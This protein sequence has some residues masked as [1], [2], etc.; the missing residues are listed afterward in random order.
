MTGNELNMNP[1]FS[2]LLEENMKKSK[3]IITIITKVLFVFIATIV[4]AMVAALSNM[5]P[6]YAITGQFEDTNI[7][8]MLGFTRDQDPIYEDDDLNPFGK[9]VKAQAIMSELVLSDTT[10]F[11]LF[12]HDDIY[13]QRK[14]AN[15]IPENNS[16]TVDLTY[17]YDNSLAIAGEFTGDGYDDGM[18]LVGLDITNVYDSETDDEDKPSSYG[19]QPA[20]N[21]SILFMDPT[22]SVDT[23]SPYIER[24]K[25]YYANFASSIDKY[26]EEGD[27]DGEKFEYSPENFSRFPYQAQNYLEAVTGDFTGDGIDELAVYFANTGNAKVVVYQLQGQSTSTGTTKSW[28]IASNWVAV[29]TFNLNCYGGKT[30]NMVDLL[31]E[32]L[33]QDGVDDLLISSGHYYGGGY[34]ETH[35]VTRSVK[36]EDDVTYADEKVKEDYK[37]TESYIPTS[38]NVMLGSRDGEYL[39]DSA[40]IPVGQTVRNAFDV[41]DVDGDGKKELIMGAQHLDQIRDSYFNNRMLVAYEFDHYLNN[42]RSVGG[43]NINITETD[44]IYATDGSDN[45]Y[46]SVPGMKANLACVQQEDK[47]NPELIYLDSVMYEYKSGNFVIENRM[48]EDGM[49]PNFDDGKGAEEEGCSGDEYFQYVE[50]GAQSAAYDDSFHEQVTTFQYFPREHDKE[51]SDD[52]S[53]GDNKW[54]EEKWNY[55]SAFWWWHDESMYDSDD[56]KRD[57]GIGDYYTK[58]IYMND[59]RRARLFFL[60]FQKP[61]FVDEDETDEG[62]PMTVIGERVEYSVGIRIS[63]KESTTCIP[64]YK[65]NVNSDNDTCIFEYTGDHFMM[66]SEPEVLAVV[67]SP[68]YFSDLE[69]LEGGD[70][71]IGDS[72]SLYYTIEGT[73]YSESESETFRVGA[74]VGVAYSWEFKLFGIGVENTLSLE[75]ETEFEFTNETEEVI[76][77]EIEL[78]FG[79]MGGQD[80]VAL[81]MVPV[82]VFSYNLKIPDGNGGYN[83]EETQLL[84]KHSPKIRTYSVG[85]YDQIAQYYEELPTVAGK[86][87]THTVGSPESYFSNYSVTE[88][89]PNIDEVII[90]DGPWIEVGYDANSFIEYN[91]EF[92]E[93]TTDTYTNNSTVNFTIDNEIGG[94]FKVNFGI[95][96]G[97]S[98]EVAR[99]TTNISGRGFGC[100]LVNMPDEAEDYGYKYSIKM[101]KYTYFMD[102]GAASEDAEDERTTIPVFTYLVDDVESPPTLPVDLDIMNVTKNSATLTWTLPRW[103]ATKV[104]Y[105]NIYRPITFAS[106]NMDFLIGTVSAN[107][108]QFYNPTTD[109]Y[110]YYMTDSSLASDTTYP[111]YIEAIQDRIEGGRS[112]QSPIVQAHTLPDVPLPTITLSKNYVLAYA[113]EK[114]TITSQISNIDEAL[115]TFYQWEK[116]EADKFESVLGEEAS[117]L[118]LNY[119]AYTDEGEYRL[120]VNQELEGNILISSYSNILTVDHSKRLPI[121]TYD[122]IRTDAG[123][124]SA[125]VKIINSNPNSTSYP[126]GQVVF[127]VKDSSGESATIVKDVIPS[128]VN[129]YSYVELTDYESGDGVFYITATYNGS[130]VFYPTDVSERQVIVGQN[131][132]YTLDMNPAVYYGDY[133]FPTVTK[134]TYD[135]NLQQ[136]SIAEDAQ[137]STY[138]VD[139]HKGDGLAAVNDTL[140]DG[141]FAITGAYAGE[142]LALLKDSNGV[143]LVE[144]TFEVLKRPITITIPHEQYVVGNAQEQQISLSNIACLT[145]TNEAYPLGESHFEI[146]TDDKVLPFLEGDLVYKNALGVNVEIDSS[147]SIGDYTSTLQPLSDKACMVKRYDISFENGG[148]SVTSQPYDV[149]VITHN[150]QGEPAGSVSVLSPYLVTDFP[151]QF[152]RDTQVLFEANPN[153][154]YAVDYWTINA[155]I[156]QPNDK[157]NE[158]VWHLMDQDIQVDVYF[159]VDDKTLTYGA[160]NCILECTNSNVLS[161][162]DVVIEGAQYTFKATPDAG[163]T[164][165]KWVLYED[166]RL[167][168]EVLGTIDENGISTYDIK[169]KNVSTVFYAVAKRSEYT[170][171]LGENLVGSYLWDNDNNTQ[172][173]DV[174]EKFEGTKKL[175]GD[176]ALTVEPLAGYAISQDQETGEYQW[177]TDPENVGAVAANGQS[178]A[179]S[180]TKDV[181]VSAIIAQGVYGVSFEITPSEKFLSG[182]MNISTASGRFS[183]EPEQTYSFE[184]GSEFNVSIDAPRGYYVSGWSVSGIDEYIL[185]DGILYC[186]N[187]A[188]NATIRAELTE[189]T[190]HEITV[191]SSDEGTVYATIEGNEEKEVESGIVT[192]Y[193]GEDVTFRAA[194]DTDFMVEK[195]LVDGSDISS[196]SK[197]ISLENIASDRTVEVDF[198]AQAYYILTYSVSGNGNL[199]SV[200]REG[201]VAL[202][203]GDAV[204]GGYSI[205]F[206][207]QQVLDQ[208]SYFSHWL[209]NGEIYK[210]QFNEQ[211][212]GE[213]LV[214]DTLTKDTDVV[215][216]FDDVNDLLTE[217]QSTFDDSMITATYTLYDTDK[218]DVSMTNASAIDIP[219]QG[220]VTF[221]YTPSSGM[222]TG[223]SA[224]DRDGASVAFENV[225][226]LANGSW[227]CSE[228]GI[229]N[230][231]YITVVAIDP[232]NNTNVRSVKV[233]G[234]DAAVRTDDSGTFDVLFDYEYDLASLTAGAFNIKLEDANATVIDIQKD[235]SAGVWHFKAL[236]QDRT[237]FRIYTVIPA[238]KDKP[239]VVGD[240]GIKDEYLILQS[241][242]S[243]LN[244][245]QLL[246]EL[247]IAE[248]YTV[249]I[250]TSLGLANTGQKVGT[251]HS[252]SLTGGQNP[253]NWTVILMGDSTG[254]GSL[255]GSDSVDIKLHILDIQGL[256]G[257][258]FAAVDHD[259]NSQINTGDLNTEK[260]LILNNLN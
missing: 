15:Q 36:Q 29:R 204:G 94:N 59:E 114:H 78:G 69:V 196:V 97:Y 136:Y 257:I 102:D 53:W 191:T 260:Q 180:V 115:N 116:W 9:G 35:E 88:G 31:G 174:L 253:M 256:A 189:L 146:D 70:N 252:L 143:T 56:S 123:K 205:E 158:L 43:S 77:Q 177:T 121:M 210:N 126:T 42:F 251:G 87:L 194:A 186:Q 18:V 27:S 98:K 179:F 193:E 7:F 22:E 222:I 113:D 238:V 12:D 175:P 86:L 41:G 217:I 241:S 213:T 58:R 137:W 62:D 5:N 178:L 172:T 157:N 200:T 111:F 170:I 20:A 118:D 107:D 122:E 4:I 255:N 23:A 218:T 208:P 6:A 48:Y 236:A 68:P 117:S 199:A 71:Y 234:V 47:I 181:N 207:V 223:V 81:Y 230:G 228:Y 239:I 83:T 245:D 57:D 201:G 141:K 75:M 112:V 156:V 89:S 129:R 188:Q 160:T 50:Y 106:G 153:T 167:I 40:N 84:I 212:I 134:Y 184:G 131:D 2:N 28:M 225:E 24:R 147:T 45:I 152:Y 51:Y 67:A 1:C 224:V 155:T 128:P 74:H 145:G 166:G 32:D 54:R 227:V 26:V 125:K 73:S 176:A 34:V 164:F 91:I 195:W 247:T 185:V 151:T 203:D 198:I 25:S 233:D 215:A 235:E 14:F 101:M 79:A 8:D 49:R 63:N 190:Q 159:K 165:E 132:Y 169:M 173:A 30:P 259:E 66:Y 246:S 76:S 55:H 120:R 211:Y 65:T 135:T 11:T 108:M 250:Y 103:D 248:E 183:A 249:S 60:Q 72:E 258:E 105:F 202:N 37:V 144:K 100:T 46:Y 243:D 33:N 104:D 80:T 148:L 244:G 44:L 214:L 206:V 90:Q 21:L 127:V 168:E 133:V 19:A 38:A 197:T 237:T 182:V 130:Y 17:A 142:W 64:F 93:E 82:E 229:S 161:S 231:M 150:V 99:S 109:E 219:M 13:A 162:G 149:A 110:R 187:L 154:G 138:S 209:V 92:T 124:F 216:V 3:Q 139:L 10:G 61:E 192:L 163:Y 140:D 254:D 52:G 242:M 240:G 220:C 226:V 95:T 221:K 119:I 232:S 39:V 171:S 96:L 16:E 85:D